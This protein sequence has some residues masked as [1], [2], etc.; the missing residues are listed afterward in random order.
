M[1]YLTENQK[2]FY[3]ENGFVHLENFFSDDELQEISSDYNNIFQ[4]PLNQLQSGLPDVI[5][6]NQKS[7]FG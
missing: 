7:H 2:L 5:F 6:S 1:K 4:V 3:D